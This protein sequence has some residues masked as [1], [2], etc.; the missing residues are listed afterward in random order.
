MQTKRFYSQDRP[1]Q[2]AGS[3][4]GP[5][6]EPLVTERAE[7]FVG[8]SLRNNYLYLR[9]VGPEDYPYLYLVETSGSMAARWGLR[10]ATPAYQEWVQQRSAG[11]LAQ[12][13]VLDAKDDS[14]I[15][16]VTAFSADFQDGHAHLA[17]LSFDPD[18][19]SMMMMLGVGLFVEYVF[20]CWNF[21]KLYLDTAEY[22]YPQFASGA[23]K[24]FRVEGRLREHHYLDGEW[25]DHLILA[26]FR[27]DWPEASQLIG[28]VGNWRAE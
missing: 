8:P 22:N 12:F 13:M 2:P 5:A 4:D 9:A 27:E 19:N 6:V 24:F 20:K 3:S 15:G 23:G 16:L 28:Q 7:R 21:R 10:G 17:A 11:V 1:G 18:G 26:I 14:R 25:W